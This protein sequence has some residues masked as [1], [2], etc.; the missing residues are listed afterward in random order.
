[1]PS[2]HLKV[3]KSPLAF[4]N[5][6]PKEWLTVSVRIRGRPPHGASALHATVTVFVWMMVLMVRLLR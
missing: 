6:R 1:M 3:H 5:P 4:K 2:Q